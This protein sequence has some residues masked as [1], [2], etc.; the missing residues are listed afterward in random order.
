MEESSTI[1]SN[2]K[3]II[4]FPSALVTSHWLRWQRPRSA[5]PGG[6]AAARGPRQ[7]AD[8]SGGPPFEAA[9]KGDQ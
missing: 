1:P 8:P 6:C 4:P 3:T 7:G 2:L 9:K 5:P